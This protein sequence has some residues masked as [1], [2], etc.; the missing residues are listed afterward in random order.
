MKSSTLAS[1][2]VLT[3]LV[4]T[5]RPTGN[6]LAFG[7]VSSNNHRRSAWGTTI[8]Q[9]QQQQQ[10]RQNFVLTRSVVAAA[11]ATD[12]TNDDSIVDQEQSSQQG[13][14]AVRAP[15]KYVG[16]Y[17]CLALRFPNLAT[18]RQRQSNATGV[19]LDFVLDTA[20]NTNTIQKQVATELNLDVV[21]QA[22]PGVS[23]AGVLA[24]AAQGG[25]AD[26]Y[27]LGDAQLDGIVYDEEEKPFTF[28][29]KLTA[30]A[31]PVA[32]PA[33]AGLLIFGLFASV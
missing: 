4:S 14:M 5:S 1:A 12:T 2:L 28:M 13:T 25:G 22:L 29:S 8:R 10:R 15:L 16:P 20:A 31:L 17:P 19:S 21:G 27:M 9:Q 23:A 26:T 32:N 18:A 11:A 6:A 30:S 24:T 7:V 33:A 3:A